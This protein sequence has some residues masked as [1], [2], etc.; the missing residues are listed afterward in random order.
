MRR[1]TDVS[2]IASAG[3]QQLELHPSDRSA[4]HRSCS[5]SHTTSKICSGA[6]RSGVNFSYP[7]PATLWKCPRSSI[8]QVVT[9]GGERQ[10]GSIFNLKKSALYVMLA[11]LLANQERKVTQQAHRTSQPCWTALC[12]R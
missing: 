10:T 11:F 4:A 2:T 1:R 8:S 3:W 12:H 5:A 6:C 7:V 9:S